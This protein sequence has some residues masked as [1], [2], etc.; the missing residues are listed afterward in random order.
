MEG[1]RAL[2]FKSDSRVKLFAFMVILVKTITW[3]LIFTLNWKLYTIMNPETNLLNKLL[4]LIGILLLLGVFFFN[5]YLFWPRPTNKFSPFLP[6]VYRVAL[7]PEGLQIYSSF[8]GK[9]WEVKFADIVVLTS[10]GHVVH[11]GKDGI[12]LEKV[13]DGEWHRLMAEIE[14]KP[15]GKYVQLNL[16]LLHG[17]KDLLEMVRQRAQGAVY[18]DLGKPGEEETAEKW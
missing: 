6:F 15:R 13:R 7:L 5:I 12:P 1:D 4:C 8:T 3:S 14:E 9:P 2:L 16:S 11:R 18:I 17:G 10:A